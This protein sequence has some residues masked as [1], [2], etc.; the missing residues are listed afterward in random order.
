MVIECAGGRATQ[1]NS[2]F[3]FFFLQFCRFDATKYYEK[4]NVA[5]NRAN[6]T[7]ICQKPVSRAAKCIPYPH[8]HSQVW[9]LFFHQMREK[10]AFC[11]RSSHKRNHTTT[12][13]LRRICMDALENNKHRIMAAAR[14][15]WKASDKM[16]PTTATTT[17]IFAGPKKWEKIKPDSSRASAAVE[18]KKL[19]Y[20]HFMLKRSV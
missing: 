5:K 11:V 14:V 8:T 19:W 17:A 10:K 4:A 18:E 15:E 3:V 16:K 1:F 9:V 12:Q 7:H 6:L 20:L 13:P 2:F